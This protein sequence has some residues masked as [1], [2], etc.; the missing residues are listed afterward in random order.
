MK[1]LFSKNITKEQ[2]RDTGMAVV[3]VLLVLSVFLQNP[4]FPKIAIAALILTMTIPTVYKYPAILWFG[5]SQL[6]GTIVSKLLLSFIFFL[7]VTPVGL[8]R[9]LMGYDSLKLKEFGK[10]KESVMYIRNKTFTKN[11]INKPF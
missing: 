5:L 11:D 10:N 9:R 6:I 1:N 3:L 8:V 4:D 7:V 2:S